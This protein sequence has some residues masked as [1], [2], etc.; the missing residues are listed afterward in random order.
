MPSQLR[1]HDRLCPA[2]GYGPGQRMDICI[3]VGIRIGRAD[4][5]KKAA[6]RIET[7]MLD[8]KDHCIEE[9]NAGLTNAAAAVRG[10]FDE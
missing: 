8:P 9:Y 4:E 6:Q 5:R 10:E 1:N 7:L 3:C 2:H